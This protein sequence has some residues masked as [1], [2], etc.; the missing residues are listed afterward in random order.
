MMSAL[1]TIAGIYSINTPASHGQRLT[2][3]PLVSPPL[4]LTL[5]CTHYKHTVNIVQN[6]SLLSHV[7]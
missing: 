5:V 7:M 2:I 1:P 4:H 6:I 3:R